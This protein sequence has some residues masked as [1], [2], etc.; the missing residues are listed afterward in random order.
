[1]S[2]VE[3]ALAPEMQFPIALPPPSAPKAQ[4]EPEPAPVP[5]PAQEKRPYQPNPAVTEMPAECP[6]CGSIKRKQLDSRRLPNTPLKIGDKIFPG[7]IGRRVMCI[8][9]RLRYFV[10][11]PLEAEPEPPAPPRPCIICEKEHAPIALAQI[12]DLGGICRKCAR[13]KAN[14]KWLSLINAREEVKE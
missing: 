5:E 4:P 12:A 2:T 13:L 9:C 7:R 10:N 6:R 11:V 8:E 14:K 3:K 1:M